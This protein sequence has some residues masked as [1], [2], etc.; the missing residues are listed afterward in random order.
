M[1]R[2]GVLEALE[3]IAGVVGRLIFKDGKVPW[4]PL[5]FSGWTD[6][7][8]FP[9]PAAQPFRRLWKKQRGIRPWSR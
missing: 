9:A 1:G 6:K 3:R 8:D 4:L 2:A 5:K 7:R